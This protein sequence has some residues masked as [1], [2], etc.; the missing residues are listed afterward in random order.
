MKRNAFI[1]SL[2]LTA[3]YVT[4]T[5]AAPL[6]A[7]ALPEMPLPSVPT[8]DWLGA[9]LGLDWIG[10]SRPIGMQPVAFRRDVLL[11]ATPV[12]ATVRVSASPT[13]LLWVNGQFINQGPIR[14]Y[15]TD[16]FYDEIDLL[17]YLKQGQNHLAVLLTAPTGVLVSGL[18]TRQGFILDGAITTTDQVVPVHT[19]GDKWR[20][21]RADWYAPPLLLASLPTGFQEHVTGQS[22]EKNWQTAP[23]DASWQPP[24]YLGPAQTPPWKR[25]NPRPVPLLTEQVVKPTFVWRGTSS[26]TLTD[27]HENLAVR[28]NQE[29]V[30]GQRVTVSDYGAFDVAQDNVLTFDFGRTRLIRPGVDLQNVQGDLRVEFYYALELED[31]PGTMVGFGSSQ[32][33]FVDTFRPAL[34]NGHWMGITARGCRFL[35]LK[36]TGTGSGE[37]QLACRIVDYQ[38]PA[39]ATLTTADPFMQAVWKVS[40]ASIRSSSNDVFVDTCSRENNAWSLDSCHQGKAAFYTFGE[41]KLWRRSLLLVMQGID[42][43]GIPHAVNPAERT[44]AI[45]FDQ[46]MQC[47]GS[48]WDYYMAT[49][50]VSLLREAAPAITRLATLCEQHITTDNLFVPPAY[51][52]HWV[53]W[54]A[55]E[56]DPYSLPVNCLLTL[57]A[58]SANRI[59]GV[60]RNQSL[61]VVRPTHRHASATGSC[62]VLRR[63]KW[64][65]PRLESSR[66]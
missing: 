7:P 10:D 21:K 29:R 66:R 65:F 61:Q 56:R 12:R 50:D 16:Y 35:T 55:I 60:L 39:N 41:T 20:T 51:S 24:F 46:T 6:T 17:P 15:T 8:S 45:L 13:Y 63:A 5:P 58:E 36:I 11:S 43:A 53:D 23:P 18:N 40:D 26:R 42:E 22:D 30:E 33:G 59:A 52:W 28:F 37:L 4:A 64:P 27:W 2:A 19:E 44:Y 47:V 31:R 1:R 62:P 48:C 34:G 49:A 57:M 38:F 25:L 9:W 32:E 3:G 14:A 54:A